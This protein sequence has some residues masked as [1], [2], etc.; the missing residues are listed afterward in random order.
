M[1]ALAW[2]WVVALLL[3]GGVVGALAWLGPPRPAAL[4]ATGVPAPSAP[5]PLAAATPAPSPGQASPARAPRVAIMVAGVG[6][7]ASDTQAAIASLPAV[8]SLAVSPYAPNPAEI[9][10]EARAAGHEVIVSLPMQPAGGAAAT[11]GDEALTTGQKASVTATRLAWALGRVPQAAGTTSLLGRGLD[12]AAFV[13]SPALVGVTDRLT[14]RHLWFLDARQI[15]ML[16]A[17]G[18]SLAQGLD[19]VVAQARRQG[20]AIGAIGAPSPNAVAALEKLL[21]AL[22]RRGVRL[23]PV[24]QIMTAQ[25]R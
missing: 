16:D 22:A 17:P 9:A 19:N 5:A 21:P 14:A 2:F 11:A 20:S 25:K 12:G 10:K 1:R 24:G 4:H 7:I 13:A 6:M 18:G 23:V 3:A 8:V 15:T